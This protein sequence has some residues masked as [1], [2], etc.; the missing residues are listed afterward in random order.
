MATL[1]LNRAAIRAVAITSPQYDTYARRRAELLKEVAIRVFQARQ[2][3]DN[4]ER[5]SEHTPPKYI[6][7]WKIERDGEGH[8]LINTDPAANLVE[9]GARAGGE[10][11]VLKYRP[12]GTALEIVSNQ[13]GSG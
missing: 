4:E 2:R 3:R 9:W 6:V 10:T 12:M 13:G 11:P 1:R 5:T 8:K 7:S